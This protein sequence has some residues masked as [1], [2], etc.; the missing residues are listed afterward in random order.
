MKI[1]KI[2]LVISAIS[3]FALTTMS[4]QASDCSGYKTFSH[5]W[6]MCKGGRVKEFGKDGASSETKKEPG[7]I[8][9][10]FKKI[11]EAGGKNIGEPG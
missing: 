3:F 10:F 2:T 11:K 5:K 7:K 1:K 8:G 6:I 9:S 4:A